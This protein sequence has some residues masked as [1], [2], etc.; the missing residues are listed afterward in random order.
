MKQLDMNI[1]KGKRG[2]AR[3]NAGR[4]RLHSKGVSHT[5]RENVNSNTPMH[6][7]FKYSTFIKTERML[8]ILETA[9]FNAIKFDFE[10]CYYTIQSNQIH[11]IAEAKDT[12]ALIQGMRS[13]THTIVK[14]LGKGSIQIERYH[15]HVLKNPKETY[16]ALNYVINNEQRHTGKRDQRFTNTYSSADSW[17]LQNAE[18]KII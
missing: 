9:C 6:I 15:L 11:L 17:L 2:G 1:Y 7:N 3:P 5:R 16:H 4:P 8:A 14:K 12:K 18:S 10:V 13:V